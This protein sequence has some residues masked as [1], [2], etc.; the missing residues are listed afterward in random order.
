MPGDKKGG[1]LD[2]M[3]VWLTIAADAIVRMTGRLRM[4]AVVD[5]IITVLEEIRYGVLG[6]RQQELVGAE[7]DNTEHDNSESNIEV[8]PKKYDHVHLS[9]IPDY[10]GGSL[11]TMLYA[12]PMV[13]PGRASGVLSNCLRN[14][15]LFESIGDYHNEYVALSSADDAEKLFKNKALIED[16]DD[17][18]RIVLMDYMHYHLSLIHI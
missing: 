1:L 4:E 10:I 7:R 9:N 16:W 2:Y 5:D 18:T 12:L 3:S 15:L 14:P 17:N 11:S 8:S 6:R 13:Y